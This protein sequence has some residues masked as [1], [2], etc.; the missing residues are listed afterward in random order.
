MTEHLTRVDSW[1]TEQ[2]PRMA[3]DFLPPVI[4]ALLVDQLLIDRLRSS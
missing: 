4:L 3:I 1:N 2:I